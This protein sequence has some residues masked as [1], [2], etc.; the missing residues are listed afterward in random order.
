MTKAAAPM[1]GG[2]ICP[3]VEALA[4]TA[5]AN[6]GRKPVFFMS[7]MVIGPSTM[8]LATALPEI[9]PK[10]LELTIDDLA[11][12]ARRVAGEREGEIHE[13]PP[14][15]APFHERAE[16]DEDDHVGGGDAERR[17][18]DAVRGKVHLLQQHL[19]LDA[20]EEDG[21]AQEDERGD[22]QGPPD[23]APRRVEHQDDGD[24]RH[25]LV[26]GR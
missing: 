22:G 18:E 4:S 3:P 19:H 11:G 14:R 15:A 9:V 23:D 16:Q 26:P 10:R 12:A 17:A 8:T 13:E 25:H 7:G 6:G 2:M 20:G 1:I 21:V 24:H 5:A